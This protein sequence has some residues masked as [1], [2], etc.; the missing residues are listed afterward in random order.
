M[1]AERLHRLSALTFMVSGLLLGFSYIAHP[2]QM[3]PEAIASSFWIAIH[4]LFLASIIGGLL[5]TTGFYLSTS[6]R[7]GS[8]GLLGFLAAFVGLVMI[9]GLDY[10]EIFI[11]PYLATAFTVVIAQ[12]GAGDA[13]GPVAIVFP[14]S[15]GL[16]VLGY[17]LLAVANLRV[18]GYPR[19][20]MLALLAA[21]V[22]FGV[23]LSPLGDLMTARIAATAFGL[24]LVATGF[25]Y[26]RAARIMQPAL[27]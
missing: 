8:L 3:T 26:W 7:T 11:A 4:V 18:G 6:D 22:I 1:N 23:G 9:A 12:H 27:A 14:A 15:G 20:A 24:A 2:H 10:Y 19:S 13:M 17:V 25:V 16:T 5:G 21:S